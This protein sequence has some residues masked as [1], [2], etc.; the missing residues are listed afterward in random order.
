M[1]YRK[2][3][4]LCASLLVSM[5]AINAVDYDADGCEIVYVH[6]P[7]CDAPG[8]QAGGSPSPSANAPSYG[9]S[10]SPAPANAPAY[11]KGPSPAPAIAPAYGGSPSPA[12]A[13][14]NAPAYG[15]G[16]SPAPAGSNTPAYGG[17]ATAPSPG[18]GANPSAPAPTT[19]KPAYGPGGLMSYP[20]GAWGK[21]AHATPTDSDNVH[22]IGNEQCYLEPLPAETNKVKTSQTWYTHQ[23]ESGE[24]LY[25]DCGFKSGKINGMTVAATGNNYYKKNYAN[26][27][28]EYTPLGRINQDNYQ[29]GNYGKPQILPDLTPH[30]EKL[31]TLLVVIGD[32]CSDQ[33]QWCGFDDGA[34]DVNGV[35]SNMHLDLQTDSL[36]QEWLDFRQKFGYNLYGEATMVPCPK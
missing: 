18:K 30:L 22:W 26:T 28:W 2:I 36:P 29:P 20:P 12:P 19:N 11:G 5:S 17:N 16:P 1:Q 33:N 23:P 25:T 6:A 4:S 14:S 13:G 8:Y 9:G 35:E 34:S 21:T 3:A 10:P 31:G 27:C 32:E 7:A 24:V 15:G